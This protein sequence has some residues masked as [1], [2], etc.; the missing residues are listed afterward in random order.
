MCKKLVVT[1]LAVV[2]VF[3]VLHKLELD[4]WIKHAIKRTQA[5]IKDA[6]PEEARIDDLRD[7]INKIGPE[8]KKARTVVARQ[9]NEVK[10]L[11]TEIAQIKTNLDKREA[12]ILALKKVLDT[13]ASL[14][15]IGSEQ[16]KRDKVEADRNRKWEAFKQAK[17]MLQAKEDLLKQREETLEADKAKLETMQ[18][19]K[20]ELEASA[21]RL[22][23]RLRKL[24]LTQMQQNV[25]I[26]DSHIANAQKKFEDLEKRI[27]QGETE[28]ALD[29]GADTENAVSNA[30]DR[31]AKGDQA[32][33]EIEEYFTKDAKVSKT[34]K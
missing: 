28:I 11:K 3:F 15:T 22:A 8:I 13:N 20:R 25:A 7:E 19:K 5:D 1:G 18:D 34:D 10:D 26:D 33:K 21:D 29:K 12:D 24:R 30:L 16:F 6:V 17:E 32:N 27:G 23:L 31:K 4:I 14:V 2:A 9:I